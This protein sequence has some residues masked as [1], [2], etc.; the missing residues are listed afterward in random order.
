ME[1]FDGQDSRGFSVGLFHRLY[2]WQPTLLV[3]PRDLRMTARG[4]HE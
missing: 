1:H 4:R 2:A 3:A